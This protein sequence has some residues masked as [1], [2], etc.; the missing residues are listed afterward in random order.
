MQVQ[1]DQ[2]RARAQ[3]RRNSTCAGGV[4]Q[5][6]SVCVDLV[7]HKPNRIGILRTGELVA[8][9][10]QRNQ[11]PAVAQIWWNGACARGRSTTQMGSGGVGLVAATQGATSNFPTHQ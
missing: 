4:Q 3:L 2:R 7:L 10:P 9:Q 11:R 1:E 8:F 6:N 5:L